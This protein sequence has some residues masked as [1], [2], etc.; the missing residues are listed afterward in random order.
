MIKATTDTPVVQRMRD[1]VEPIA[2]D[3]QLDVYDVEP[4]PI[5]HAFRRLDNTVVSPHLGYATVE[6]Y[7][8][9]YGAAVENLQAWLSGA[10]VRVIGQ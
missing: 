2:S 7:Q 3:L 9:F 10:P 5:D 8:G 6:N 1:L 4:L